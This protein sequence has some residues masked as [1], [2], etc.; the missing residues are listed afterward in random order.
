SSHTTG[1]P[2]VP[3]GINRE[4]GALIRAQHVGL[5]GGR[6]RRDAEESALEYVP[7]GRDDGP[8]FPSTIPR[9]IGMGSRRRARISSSDRTRACRSTATIFIGCP[10]TGLAR[11][12]SPS[13]SRYT[14]ILPR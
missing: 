9:R 6:P 14:S 1:V 5:V 3:A 2:I 8:A 4:V 10:P 11:A 12:R 13:P 7:D